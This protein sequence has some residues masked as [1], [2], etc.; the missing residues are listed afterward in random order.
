[1]V[2]NI[3]ALPSR[4][5]Y[6]EQFS[7]EVMERERKRKELL[8]T[9]DHRRIEDIIVIA[10]LSI[11]AFLFFN[12]PIYVTTWIICSLLL[13]SFY[14]ILSLIPALARWLIKKR[15]GHQEN[16]IKFLQALK[17]LKKSE[18]FYHSEWII[19]FI[20]MRSAAI[21]LIALCS[22][23]ILAAIGYIFILRQDI[24]IGSF[25]AIQFLLFFILYFLAIILKPYNKT[26]EVWIGHIAENLQKK[27]PIIWVILLIIGIFGFFAALYFLAAYLSPATTALIVMEWEHIGP[28]DFILEFSFILISQYIFIRYIHSL[29]SR[30]MTAWVSAAIENFVQKNVIPI[31]EK[32][33]Q[34]EIN[35]ADIECTQYRTLM[36]SLLEAKMFKTFVTSIYGLYPIYYFKPDLSLILDEETLSALKGHM[37]LVDKSKK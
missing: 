30:R 7:R 18:Q 37:S 23:N 21:A 27:K 4:I 28:L 20:N 17:M 5:T 34:G 26:F 12:F 6:L 32:A 11:N 3:C 25:V 36:A 8:A 1:M 2:E 15:K 13:I 10:I 16:H 9:I 33:R 24:E 22:S 14:P 29:E 19:F 35:E 31:I